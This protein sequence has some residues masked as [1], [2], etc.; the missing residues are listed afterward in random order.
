MRAISVRNL[1]VC[2]AIA[3][4]P[5]IASA[6]EPIRVLIL[7]GQNNHDWQVTTPWLEKALEDTARFKVSVTESPQTL[8]AAALEGFD[9]IV[10]NWNSFVEEGVKEW[11]EP[12]R[13]ALLSF[14]AEGKG[15]VSVHAGS[16]S[17]YDW[18]EYQAM[19]MTYWDHRKTGHGRV[20][21]FEVTC[22]TDHPITNGLP[23]FFTHDELWHEAPVPKE[24]RVL[25]TAFSSK[26]SGG[27]G[28]NEPVLMVREYGKG[29]SVNLLLGHDG[30]AMR[31]YGF[32]RLFTRGV[33]WAATGGVART[34]DEGGT[35]VSPVTE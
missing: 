1:I 11:P 31:H 27:S 30:R 34:W 28:K 16:S 20:H 18:P 29:R 33:E 6:T 35:I 17:F 22:D 9:V 14:V 2:L 13:S 4:L 23:R 3:W 10:S 8:D 25:A 26:E 32:I 7:S 12:A 24:A 15:F 21:Q 19:V 5:L